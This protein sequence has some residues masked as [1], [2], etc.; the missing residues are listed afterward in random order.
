MHLID[1]ISENL[2]FV[3]SKPENKLDFLEKL[4][5]CVKSRFASIDEAALLDRLKE[6]EEVVSTGI[7]HG[8]AIPHATIEGIDKTY[9]IVAQISDGV[10]FQSLDAAEVHIVFLLL[11]PSEN[12]GTHLRLLARIARVVMNEAFVATLAK[13]E[14]NWEIFAL[15]AEEDSRHV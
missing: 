7:G 8:V 11:S 5:G 10:D 4:V 9:C 6:R 3:L 13:A 12:V 15:I 1:Y 14:V 2:I